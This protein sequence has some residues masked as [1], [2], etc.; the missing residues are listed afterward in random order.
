MKET[1]F[2]VEESD[3]AEAVALA[4]DLC[5]EQG[6]MGN[7][8]EAPA[9]DRASAEV[10]VHPYRHGRFEVRIVQSGSRYDTT[11]NGGRVTHPT[12]FT[13]AQKFVK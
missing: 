7:N 12:K 11:S 13:F 10:E 5:P 4:S 1:N 6:H 9:F 8:W 2:G 3:F